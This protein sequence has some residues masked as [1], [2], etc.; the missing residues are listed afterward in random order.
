M[1]KILEKA[2]KKVDDAEIFYLK[3]KEFPV[4]FKSNSFYTAEKKNFEG[5]GIRVIN[6]GK[7]GFSN[8]TKIEACG[9]ILDYAK[10]RV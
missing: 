4:I 7:L 9:D 1:I 8:T 5:L 10:D 3:G 6:N 2:K